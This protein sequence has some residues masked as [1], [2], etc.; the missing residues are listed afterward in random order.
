MRAANEPCPEPTRRRAEIASELRHEVTL[1]TEPRFGRDGSKRQTRIPHELAGSLKP[2]ASNEIPDRAPEASMELASDMHRMD[3]GGTGEFGQR[4]TVDERVLNTLLHEP[5]PRRTPAAGCD[6][7]SASVAEEIA[8]DHVQRT[9][10]AVIAAID[11]LNQAA[12]KN[13]NQFTVKATCGRDAA[14]LLGDAGHQPWRQFNLQTRGRDADGVRVGVTC[15]KQSNITRYAHVI[16]PANGFRKSARRH[17]C[18]QREFVRMR[19]E[20]QAGRQTTV[21]DVA[22]GHTQFPDRR[23][24]ERLPS[25]GHEPF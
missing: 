1:I 15:R 9:V 8:D 25:R 13:W 11:L 3:I 12:P 6:V 14:G 23:T 10:G 4:H 22:R 5:K 17:H 18:Q 16:E 2:E 20:R 21:E 24:G 19:L 7:T